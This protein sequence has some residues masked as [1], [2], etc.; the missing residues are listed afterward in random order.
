VVLDVR[1]DDNVLSFDLV[2]WFER[3]I[4]S[5]SLLFIFDESLK[6]GNKLQKNHKMKNSI[7]LDS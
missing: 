1:L 4:L 5:F 6:N 3:M 7:L 2:E